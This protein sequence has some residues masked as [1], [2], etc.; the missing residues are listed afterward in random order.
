LK[1]GNVS[2][3]E[4]FF[5]D[6]RLWEV[7]NIEEGSVSIRTSE[8][9]HKSNNQGVT[10]QTFSGDGVIPAYFNLRTSASMVIWLRPGIEDEYLRGDTRAAIVLPD[11]VTKLKWKRDYRR[12]G[13]FVVSDDHQNWLVSDSSAELGFD[14]ISSVP[15]QVGH[16]EVL[17]AHDPTESDQN[18]PTLALILESSAAARLL[19]IDE[20]ETYQPDIAE[21]RLVQGNLGGPILRDLA[22][23]INIRHT[24][25]LMLD[26]YDQEDA[27]LSYFAA[28]AWSWMNFKLQNDSDVAETIYQSVKSELGS[29]P[30]EEILNL[31]PSLVWQGFGPYTRAEFDRESLNRGVR[32]EHNIMPAWHD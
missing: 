14:A 19:P 5:Q 4:D 27:N 12:V 32:A 3:K 7:L 31:V 26:R 9:N 6:F 20:L 25:Q 2:A 18:G 23:G 22:I 8:T 29:D 11:M 1:W 16:Y 24:L 15:L 30:M 17:V 13:N 10:I 21:N 28:K